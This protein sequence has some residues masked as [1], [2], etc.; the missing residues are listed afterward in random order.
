[1]RCLSGTSYGTVVTAQR[2]RDT[3]Q[4]MSFSLA[5]NTRCI[6]T[7]RCCRRHVAK[8]LWTTLDRDAWG[9]SKGLPHRSKITKNMP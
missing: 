4:D 6:L 7:S 9:C 5:L 2:T 3:K 1:M 8:R